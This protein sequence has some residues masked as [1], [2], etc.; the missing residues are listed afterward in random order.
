MTEGSAPLLVSLLIGAVLGSWHCAAMCGPLTAAFYQ[1]KSLWRFHLGKGVAYVSSG[2]IAGLLGAR[3]LHSP[4]LPLKIVSASIL[5][6]ILALNLWPTEVLKKLE[7]RLPRW[8]QAPFRFVSRRRPGLFVM[9]L[10]SLLLPCG[11][12]WTFITAAIA[13]GS[14]WSGA[15]VMSILWIS[16]VP[17]LSAVHLYFRRALSQNSA[18]PTSLTVGRL[19]RWAPKLLSLAGFYAL[20]SHFIQLS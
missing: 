19:R 12:M 18:T 2:A 6:L 17:V 15:L 5:A 20:I 8:T 14:P 3:L 9:G 7:K 1:K 16:T 4:S 13:T 10:T 11:W